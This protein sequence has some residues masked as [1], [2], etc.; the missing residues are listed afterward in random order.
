V[1]KIQE[2][3][4]PETAAWLKDDPIIIANDGSGDLYFDA[5]TPDS[6]KVKLLLDNERP[7]LADMTFN[8]PIFIN[9]QPIPPGSKRS[10]KHGDQ[11]RISN[12]LFEIA[13]PKS[14]VDKLQGSG[15]NNA[16]P[17]R[18]KT[19]WRLK[20]TGNW[21]DGQVFTLKGKSVIGR[22]A[23]CTITIPGSHMSRRHAEFLVVGS[24]LIMK[25]LDSSNG[26]FVNGTRCKETQLNDGDEIKL[27]VLTFRVVAPEDKINSEKKSTAS[28]VTDAPKIDITET[29]K[30]TDKNWVTKPTSIGNAAHD[31]H[32]IILAKHLRTQRIN[33]AVFGVLMCILL[34][35]GFINL[36]T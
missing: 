23:S 14:V 18:D 15:T 13:D 21:L 4:K 33:Y 26:S 17:V 24:K 31:P 16:D 30:E 32:D 34:V 2:K 11:I 27:D 28:T 8:Q 9:D 35:I 29:T 7:Y 22:D 12:S 3:G 20:A 19:N 5:T 6:A 1:F 10:L 36:F 25:D